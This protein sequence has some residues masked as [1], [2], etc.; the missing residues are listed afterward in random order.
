MRLINKDKYDVIEESMSDSNI[1]ARK[2]KNI[3]NHISVVNSI[4]HDVLNKKSNEPID[5]MVLDY[6]QMFGSE[7][8]HE[9]M[10]SVF[11]AGIT[12][13]MFSLIY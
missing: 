5:T 1:G 11:E 4:L 8:L 9:S 3:R 10:N 12:D 2:K 6:K 13:D 7:C